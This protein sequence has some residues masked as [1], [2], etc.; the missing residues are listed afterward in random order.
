MKQKLIGIALFLVL[1]I[2]ISGTKLGWFKTK[3]ITESPTVVRYQEESDVTQ[4]VDQVTPSVVS[5]GIKRQ[6]QTLNPGNSFFF[7]PFGF[8]GQQPNRPNTQ[9]PQEQDIGSGFV[10]DPSGL[11]V[12]SKHVVAESGADYRVITTDDKEL[13]VEKIYR[14]PINDLAILKVTPPAGGLKA[15]ALGDSNNLK[16]G[17]TV[18]AIGTAL[19]EFRST[20][21]TG[22]ISGLGRGID[23]GGPFGG[24]SE[25]LDNVIQT[26][27]AINPGNSGGPLLNSRGEVIGVNAAIAQNGQNIGFALPINVV[28]SAIDNFNSTGKFS[29]PFFGVRYQLVDQK[30]AILNSIP[31]GAYVVEVVSGSPAEKAGIKPGDIITTVDGN[32]LTDE[33]S[34]ATIISKKKVGDTVKVEIYRDNQNQTLDV[35]LVETSE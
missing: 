5:V 15:V 12:T 3:S 30:T 21:T 9:T 2:G 14:D 7:D 18:I 31:R 27:A 25:R 10:I 33:N 28:K 17:Q 16:V 8:F 32:K 23:A 11:V 13:K 29:R 34:L 35:T 6:A 4:V 26:D 22:V 20:V 1:V 19:G 24:G